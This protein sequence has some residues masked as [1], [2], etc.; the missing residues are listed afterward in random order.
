MVI[1]VPGSRTR[2]ISVRSLRLFGGILGGT[3]LLVAA[4]WWGFIPIGR[5]HQGSSWRTAIRGPRGGYVG[6]NACRQCHPGESAFFERSG[7]ALTLQIAAEVPLARKLD[8][9]VVP[10]PEQPDVRWAYHLGRDQFTAERILP[11]GTVNRHVLEYAFGSDHHATTFVTLDQW[12][13]RPAVEH[14]L[15]HYSD[16]ETFRITPGQSAGKPY[17]VTR[18]YGRELP[19]WETVKCFRCHATRVSAANREILKP[20]EL[21]PNVSCERC[22]GPAGSHVEKALAGQTDLSMPFAGERI[23]AASQMSLC[24]QCHRHPDQ[25]NPGRIRPEVAELVR[26]QPVGIMQSRCYTESAGAFSCVNCHDPHDRASADRASYEAACLKCHEAP[27]GTPCPRSPNA[28]CVDCHMPRVDSGQQVLFTDHWIRVRKPSDPPAA[29]G[30][31]KN[32]VVR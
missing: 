9:V 2:L 21:I 25:A 28:G 29:G 8:G 17:P 16:D 19:D 24:G 27:P 31:L 11:D 20:E 4:Y 13:R 30:R 14:R 26:F 5:G 15:T 23:T 3:A 18:V 32:A 1:P 10:D 7:H 6:S 22:H 12:P